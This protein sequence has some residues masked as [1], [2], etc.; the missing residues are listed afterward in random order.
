MRLA[1]YLARLRAP[2][3]VANPPDPGALVD[4]FDDWTRDDAIRHKLFV[5]NPRALYLR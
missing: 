3:Q 2:A 4:L 1:S 5:D